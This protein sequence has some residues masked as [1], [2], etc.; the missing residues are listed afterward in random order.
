L[1]GERHRLDVWIFHARVVRTRSNA[2]DLVRAGHVRINGTRVS[3]PGQVVRLD[4]VLTI[5]LNSGVRI[6][7]VVGFIERRGDADAAHT[8][9]LDI[10]SGEAS[11]ATPDSHVP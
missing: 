5:S 4:D 6:L 9:Y 8:T 1:S 10:T 2:A 7:R 11:G 3:A